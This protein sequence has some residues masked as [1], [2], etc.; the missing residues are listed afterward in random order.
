VQ[1][2]VVKKLVIPKAAERR[3]IETIEEATKG[4]GEFSVTAISFCGQSGNHTFGGQIF[5]T[6]T[7]ERKWRIRNKTPNKTISA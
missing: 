6:E 4:G 3:I 2:K 1:K 7:D 5:L